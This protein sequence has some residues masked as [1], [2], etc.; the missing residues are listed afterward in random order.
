MRAR[1]R[2]MQEDKRRAA[3]GIDPESSD[4]T[5]PIAMARAMGVLSIEAKRSRNVDPDGRHGIGIPPP[6]IC[7][8][9]ARPDRRRH[10]CWSRPWLAVAS[11]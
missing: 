10:I 2:Q 11:K 6:V 3:S 8:R 4:P 7:T 1:W 9:L 5:L